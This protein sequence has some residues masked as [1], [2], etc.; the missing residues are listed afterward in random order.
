MLSPF[1]IG[2][3]K[4]PDNR[5]LTDLYNQMAP[6]VG[7]ADDIAAIRQMLEYLV[8]PL[9]FD[10][11]W[12][13]LPANIRA[14]REYADRL[15]GV[16]TGTGWTGLP[17]Y[18]GTVLGQQDSFD[19]GPNGAYYELLFSLFQNVFTLNAGVTGELEG[20]TPATSV[21]A[22]VTGVPGLLGAIASVLGSVSDDPAGDT[23]KE[24][25]EAIRACS[26]GDTPPPFDPA[27]PTTGCFGSAAAWTECSLSF[28]Y[29]NTEVDVYQVIFPA[30]VANLPGYTNVQVGSTV[31]NAL[32][33]VTAIDWSTART[34]C[35]AWAFQEENP[36]VSFDIVASSDIDGELPFNAY[37][38][39]GNVTPVG[40]QLN[41]IPVGAAGGT[42]QHGLYCNFA[43]AVGASPV[44][45][46][47]VMGSV[48]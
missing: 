29:T 9:V 2:T 7:M 24:L 13:G 28:K 46:V 30:S 39:L 47:W 1:R 21:L 22:Q 48:F 14:L 34:V 42:I 40:E 43:F 10:P 12:N 31:D 38:V 20:T 19:P 27:P 6:L 37:G 25:I 36:P 17:N 41:V 18:L 15:V 11:T 23:I 35:M 16:S 3:V 5:D 33:T 8:K 26:C 44:G 45:K 32:S 4:G